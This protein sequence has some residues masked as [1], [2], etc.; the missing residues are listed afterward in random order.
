[1]GNSCLFCAYGQ[2]G[3]TMT[4]KKIPQDIEEYNAEMELT[5]KKIRQLENRGKVLW[6]I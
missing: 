4:K 1:M 6:Q 5:H 3:A 2:E